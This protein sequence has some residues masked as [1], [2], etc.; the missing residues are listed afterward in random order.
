MKKT[1][2]GKP[3]FLNLKNEI[4]PLKKIEAKDEL[5]IQELIFNNPNCLPISDIDESYNPV[6][7][8]CME[9]NT[10]VGPLD[11]LMI[12]PNGELTIV[13][14]KLWRNPEAR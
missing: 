14:T 9:L 6:I 8:V 11:I 3:L 2:Y 10:T 7:P 13:E 12:S 5:A 4:T 1:A